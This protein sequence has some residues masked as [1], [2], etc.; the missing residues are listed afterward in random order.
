MN[1]RTQEEKLRG[2]S[3]RF[4]VLIPSERPASVRYLSADSYVFACAGE[5]LL[6]QNCSGTS[7]LGNSFNL[8]T[9]LRFLGGEGLVPAAKSQRLTL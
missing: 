2:K 8:P 4:N 3:K 1:L 5:R 9:S 6:S 7:D